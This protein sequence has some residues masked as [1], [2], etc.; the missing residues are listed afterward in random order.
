MSEASK[1]VT[2]I[3]ELVNKLAEIAIKG[4]E[5]Q[6]EVDSLKMRLDTIKKAMGG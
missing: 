5:K 3:C 2:Q 6:K 1:L 4:E